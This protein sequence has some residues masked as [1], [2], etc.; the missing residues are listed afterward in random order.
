MPDLHPSWLRAWHGIG[1]HGDGEDLYRALMARYGEPHRKYHTLQHLQECLAHFDAVQGVLPASAEVEAA[2]WFHDAIYDVKRSDNEERSAGWARQ[3]ALQAGVAPPVADRVHALV[4]ATRHAAVPVAEDEQWLVDIDLA[5]LGADPI[6]F[7]E[8][9][10]QIRDEYG[11][12]PGWLFQRKRRA[13][14]QAFLDRPRLFS[15]P[16]FHQALEEAARR[17]LR[18]A[19]G[20]GTA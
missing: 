9:E 6:R 2:L 14:L 1:A 12:V 4:M 11:H 8:Y 19:V 7:A 15:T 5:I 16:H 18:L 20:R 3:A 17:N 10:R 13:I